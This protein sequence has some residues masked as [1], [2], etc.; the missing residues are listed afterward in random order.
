[1]IGAVIRAIIMNDGKFINNYLIVLSLSFFSRSLF[2]RIFVKRTNVLN[3]LNVKVAI[4]FRNQSMDLLCKLINW[5]L[6]DGN[7]GV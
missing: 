6:Y 4:S 5:F 1:M 2:P 7:F 3:S